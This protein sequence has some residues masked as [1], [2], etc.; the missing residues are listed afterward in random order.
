VIEAPP[1]KELR[2]LERQAGMALGAMLA[3][4]PTAGSIRAKRDAKGHL[5]RWIGYKPHI[6]TPDGDVPVSCLLTS[7]SPHDS[8]AALPLATM[9]VARLA[10]LYDLMD[11][12]FDVLE[13]AAASRALG[14]VCRCRR[15]RPGQSWL[16][17]SP[18][19]RSLRQ[20]PRYRRWIV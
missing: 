20:R 9:T 5:T 10:N 13:I 7:A 16:R 6:D 1:P 14:H 17:P 4:L 19:V 15:S 3:E 11:S 8:Q 2:R 12:A 18:S